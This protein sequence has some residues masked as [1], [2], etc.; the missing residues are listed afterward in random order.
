MAQEMQTLKAELAL[1][2]EQLAHVNELI[3]GQLKMIEK[4]K[5]QNRE[6]RTALEVLDSLERLQAMQVEYRDRMLNKVSANH[7]AR[8][9]DSH[10]G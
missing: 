3:A 5:Q 10:S 7:L 2:E 4:W 1:A 9:Q 8:L 6:L